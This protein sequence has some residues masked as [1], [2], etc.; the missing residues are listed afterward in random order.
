MN[1]EH[2]DLSLRAEDILEHSSPV[3]RRISVINS[4]QARENVVNEIINAEREYVKHLKD[5]VEVRNPLSSSPLPLLSPIPPN[6][7]FSYSCLARY[8]KCWEILHIMFAIQIMDHH[9]MWLSSLI[10]RVT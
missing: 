4:D 1:Q 5:V 2:T 6:E 10:F 9:V 3:N 8:H 7:L